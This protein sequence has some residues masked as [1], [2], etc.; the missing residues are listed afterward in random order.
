MAL[1]Q[2]KLPTRLVLTNQKSIA[3]AGTK[4]HEGH[5]ADLVD[6]TDEDLKHPGVVAMLT[7]DPPGIA[8]YTAPSASA[9]KASAKVAEPVDDK[10]AA[11][12]AAA[13]KAAA[14]KAAADKAASAKK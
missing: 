12:K 13:D 6:L 3:P 9:V 4:S 2:N 8:L 11:D 10:A 5:P 7:Q 14:D 1:Y